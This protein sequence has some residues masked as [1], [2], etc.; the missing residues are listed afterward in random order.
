MS[1]TLWWQAGQ[2]ATLPGGPQFAAREGPSHRAPCLAPGLLPFASPAFSLSA[3][4]VT[5]TRCEDLATCSDGSRVSRGSAGRAWVRGPRSVAEGDGALGPPARCRV[6]LSPAGGGEEAVMR[7]GPGHQTG[8]PRAAFCPAL[9]RAIYLQVTA[10]KLAGGN[11]RWELVVGTLF[12][13]GRG[14]GRGLDPGSWPGPSARRYCSP[15]AGGVQAPRRAVGPTPSG[16]LRLP[17]PVAG[18]RPPHDTTCSWAEAHVP[19]E[20]SRAHPV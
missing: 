9:I 5:C 14:R 11:E 4:G 2:E 3:R 16:L 1:L 19:E 15:C 18:V 17:I 10:M 13:V 12:P 8:A 6:G 7:V 20:G